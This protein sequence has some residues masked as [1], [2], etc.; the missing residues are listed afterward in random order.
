[1]TGHFRPS[2]MHK[3]LSSTS[4]KKRNYLKNRKPFTPKSKDLFI[5]C[6]RSP[7]KELSTESNSLKPSP[8]VQGLFSTSYSLNITQLSAVELPTT[9]TTPSIPTVQ[10]GQFNSS[11][12]RQVIQ[13]SWTTV[14]TAPNTP[15]QAR[16]FE[17]TRALRRHYAI[18]YIWRN[19]LFGW[20][21]VHS[22][23]PFYLSSTRRPEGRGST[24]FG[25][26]D[27]IRLSTELMWDIVL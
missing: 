12:Q 6:F 21:I 27:S 3:V 10:Q 18:L 13:I 23:A 24:S 15:E 2:R 1:M 8:L 9:P 16:T 26:A 20:F 22:R 17:D 5:L 25:Y 7:I 14:P 4:G 19:I 11:H